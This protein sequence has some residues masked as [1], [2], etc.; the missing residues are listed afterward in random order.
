MA[1]CMKGYLEG[2]CSVVVERLGRRDCCNMEAV[3]SISPQAPYG[4]QVWV[5]L[6]THV[7]KLAPLIGERGMAL[8]SAVTDLVT[9]GLQAVRKLTGRRNGS[10]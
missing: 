1:A 2:I 8:L 9:H 5:C 3:S 10:E 7:M 4:I 6:C